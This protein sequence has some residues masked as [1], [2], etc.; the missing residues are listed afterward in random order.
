[1]SI[2]ITHMNTQII[3]SLPD[4]HSIN[5]NECRIRDERMFLEILSLFS[6]FS[7]N[8]SIRFDYHIFV[9]ECET[10][11]KFDRILLKV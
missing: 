6:S 11:I 7:K 1:M 9:N 10:Q 8:I 4:L 5:Q 3:R 2:S